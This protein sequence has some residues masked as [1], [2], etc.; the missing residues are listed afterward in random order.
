MRFI[1]FD[2]VKYQPPRQPKHWIGALSVLD[3]AIPEI[4][5]Q[6]NE[7]ALGFFGSRELTHATEFHA[8]DM[9]QGAAH[10]KGRAIA[11]RLEALEKLLSIANDDRV[12]RISVCVVPELMVASAESAPDKAFTFFVERSQIDLS[13][14][15]EDGILIGDLDG[16][17]ADQSVSNLS[18]YR[19]KG[20]PYFFGRSIDRIIDSVYF[21]PSHHSR[22]VQLADAYTYALQLLDSPPEGDKYP[23]KRIREF[24]K[25]KTNLGWA[26][27]YK[28]WPSNE[29]WALG[30]SVAA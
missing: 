21:I 9:V 17:Y 30:N 1:Y 2:E 14:T 27:S 28:I 19:E 4:E 25:S 7:I 22:M 26:N 6:I 18:E 12:R 10:F 3:S 29:S 24:L 23:K 8:V 20:T 5:A 13:K 15:K 11:D 16:Q